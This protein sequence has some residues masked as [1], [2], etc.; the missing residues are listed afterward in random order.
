MEKADNQVLPGG[1]CGDVLL[2]WW[3]WEGCVSW[4]EGDRR[5]KAR[6]VAHSRG[7][8]TL[9]LLNKKDI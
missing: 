6:A 8:V 7:Q 4:V 2:C 3:W 9:F 1:G 5:G